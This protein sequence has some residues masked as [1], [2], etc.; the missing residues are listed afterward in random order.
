MLV[1]LFDGLLLPNGIIPLT[2]KRADKS[3]PL[4]KGSFKMILFQ[5]WGR[6]A[7]WLRP[8]VARQT[9]SFRMRSMIPS[10]KKKFSLIL[11]AAL[12]FVLSSCATRDPADKV[13]A[14]V[15]ASFVYDSLA[16]SPIRATAVGY[17]VHLEGADEEGKGGTEIRLD[18][19][20]DDYSQAA[21]AKRLNFYKQFRKNLR[22]QVDRS[23]LAGDAWVITRLSRTTSTASCSSLRKSEATSTTR[24]SMSNF[25]G[26]PF[27]GP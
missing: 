15:T 4:S 21:I 13:F 20:L 9:S 3:L 12:I 23:E 17:H 2:K 14:R 1:H 7:K 18:G 10:L 11:T 16:L 27:T 26:W 22:A 8:P 25:S 19:L 5:G 6:D 24:L